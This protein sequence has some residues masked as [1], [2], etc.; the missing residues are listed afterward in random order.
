[1]KS[2]ITI[3]LDSDLLRQARIMA[4]EQGTSIS[5]LLSAR[6]EEIVRERKAFERAKKRALA[7]LNEGLDLGWAAPKSRD[8][9]HER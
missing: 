2:N 5:S 8:E 7:R 9:V 3:K 6:L 4:A 1:M